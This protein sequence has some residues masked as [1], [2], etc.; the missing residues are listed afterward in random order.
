MPVVWRRPHQ[1]CRQAVKAEQQLRHSPRPSRHAPQAGTRPQPQTQA[2]AAPRTRAER[3]PQQPRLAGAPRAPALRVVGKECVQGPQP[4]LQRLRGKRRSRRGVFWYGGSFE[5][6]RRRGGLCNGLCRAGGLRRLVRVWG[7]AQDCAGLP[8]SGQELVR[9]A[10]HSGCGWG[11]PDG[12][13]VPWAPLVQ[14]SPSWRRC[15][16]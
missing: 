7:L 6:L 4:V 9:A 11:L 3:V 8:A 13:A 16:G 10:Q 12:R 15:S 2:H 14:R 5:G 1:R